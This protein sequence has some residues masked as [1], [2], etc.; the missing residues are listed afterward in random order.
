MTGWEAQA[1]YE[2]ECAAAWEELNAP[3]PYEGVLQKASVGMKSAVDLMDKA[4][5]ALVDAISEL[6]GTPMED[7]VTAFYDQLTDLRIDL[8]ILAEKYEE[9]VR[10]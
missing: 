9:G 5:D 7:V 6:S 4:E 2:A 3:D 8:R 10:E 1:A